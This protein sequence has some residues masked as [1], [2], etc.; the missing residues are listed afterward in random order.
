M[1]RKE[2]NVTASVNVSSNV[3][4]NL[5]EIGNDNVQDNQV[6]WIFID[7]FLFIV[8]VLGNV[9]TI[10]AIAWARRL[11]NIVSNYFIFN[12]A[13]S[14][15]LVGVTLPFHLAFYVDRTLNHNKL[16]CISRFVIISLACGGS[17]YNLMVIAIDR[18]VAIVYP[19]NYSSYI[20][21]KRVLLIIIIAWI[22][23]T[24]VSS[25][26]IYWNCF[27]VSRSCELE[28]VLPRYCYNTNLSYLLKVSL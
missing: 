10:L 3:L 25:I 9:L 20:T 16:F 6:I 18:Y 4:D 21:R 22:C 15:L 17:I 7:S 5:S 1:Y 2:S 19:L 8:I 27:D 11:R 13:I 26:P 12:L 14:D 23:I 24:G 28:T